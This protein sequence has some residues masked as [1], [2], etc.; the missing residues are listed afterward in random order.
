MAAF[1]PRANPSVLRVIRGGADSSSELLS[2][3]AL[4]D[5]VQRGKAQLA[6]QLYERLIGVVDGALTRV[7]GCRGAD[8]DDLVQA[9]FEQIVITLTRRSF[10]RKCS[11]STWASK[12]AT[13]VALNTLRSRIRERRVIDRSAIPDLAGDSSRAT[14]D[15]ERQ[16]GAKRELEVLR[17]ELAAMAPEKAMVV[18]L[19]QVLGHDLAEVAA[20]S[21]VSVAAAQSRLVRGRRE[22]S[23]RISRRTKSTTQEAP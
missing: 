15:V 6:D 11:L 2:D 22:L 4:I 18:I 8:H 3:D 7:L 5:A 20:M 17:Q 16:V 9:T 19:H 1:A 14:A 10:V 13:H 21:G 23:E 12:I